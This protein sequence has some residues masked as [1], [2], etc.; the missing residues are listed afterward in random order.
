VYACIKEKSQQGKSITNLLEAEKN[1]Q[2]FFFKKTGYLQSSIGNNAQ[3]DI[4]VLRAW[5]FEGVKKSL[6]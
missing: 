1:K 5:S 3:M 2:G 6:P 4:Y